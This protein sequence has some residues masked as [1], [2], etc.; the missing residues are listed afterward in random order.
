MRYRVMLAC[1]LFMVLPVFAEQLQQDG[2]V[3]RTASPAPMKRTEVAAATV[4]AKIY[5]VG[6]FE[7][8]SWG[9]VLNFAI[10]PAVE[11]Y[12]P[13]VD[14][15]S[16]KA[17][18]PA[19]LHHVGIGVVGGR[20]Y[21]IGGYKQSGLSV[22]GPVDTVYAYDPA[23]DAWSEGAPMPTARGALSVTV[24]D[25]KLYAIGG[26]EGRANSAAV[27]AYDP[28]RNSWSA[29]ASLP[30]P[31]DHLATTTAAGKLYAIGGRLKGDYHRNLS[32]TE[33]YDPLSDKWSK[34]PDLPTARS[35]ITAA[36]AGGRVYVFGGEGVDG[37]FREN[38]A[39]DPARNAWLTMAP[40][41]TARHGLGSAVID[42]RIHVISG[43]PTPG[44]SFSNL[45]EVYSPPGVRDDSQPL[46]R[47]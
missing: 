5:V 21:I 23:T 40:M 20:L 24:H 16:T 6:G 37:T 45:N 28:V 29:R 26:Y 27:E 19:G 42:G 17:S 36:E 44:G 46:S 11:E 33:V 7:Q 12:D 14:R 43:G 8:P 30:T 25:G 38:E 32:V 15:W 1:L 4:G 22:W 3:W 13:A 39:Y 2:G 41:P 35:G 34:A 10:T 31:R 47:K 9:N 18:M